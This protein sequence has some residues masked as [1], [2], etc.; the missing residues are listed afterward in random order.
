MIDSPKNKPDQIARAVAY[1][2]VSTDEQAE[3]G[4]GLDAQSHACLC[5]AERSGLELVETCSDAGVGGATAIDKRPGLMRALAAVEGGG[6][7]LVARRDRLARDPIIVAMVESLLARRKARVV[8]AAGEGTAGDSPT[9]VLMRRICDAF[10]EYDLLKIRFN[11][12][13]AMESL[14]RRGRKAGTIPFGFRAVDDGVPSKSGGMPSLLVP[15]EAERGVID[16]IVALADRG[17][18][19]R[20][21]ARHLDGHGVAPRQ[22]G[23]WSFTTVRALLRREWEA[24]ST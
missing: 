24:Q 18:S 16:L 9:D 19:Y 21:I 15:D 22:K 8:S 17:Y 12:R 2:R 1:L 7:L 14:R 13:T 10:S 6:V 23:P 20:A 5:F 4:A 11:T 3:S